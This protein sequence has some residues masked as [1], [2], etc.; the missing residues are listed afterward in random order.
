MQLNTYVEKHGH[1]DLD[2]DEDH[3]RKRVI[4]GDSYDITKWSGAERAEC[5]YDEVDP[6]ADVPTNV[7]AEDRLLF[8]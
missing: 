1:S 8:R 7:L 6:L 5:A 2:D 3:N 4:G